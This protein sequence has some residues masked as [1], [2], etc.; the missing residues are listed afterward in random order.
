MLGYSPEADA[1][2]QQVE[3]L[4]ADKVAVSA[5]TKTTRWHWDAPDVTTSWYDSQG[6]QRNVHVVLAT[7]D[8]SLPR[9]D[10]EISA[11][12]DV[13]V[14]TKQGEQRIRH[15]HSVYLA[16]NIGHQKLPECIDKAVHSVL[17]WTINDLS[18]ISQIPVAI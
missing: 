16:R 6:V 9:F 12:L 13:D 15:W 10:V 5:D 11:S 17:D 4:L 2:L 18:N 1:I 14:P 3:S 8:I 7:D